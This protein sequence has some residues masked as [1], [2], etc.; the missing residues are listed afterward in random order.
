MSGSSYRLAFLPPPGP[1]VRTARPVANPSDQTDS[2]AP[3]IFH[4]ALA[5]RIPV[6]IHEQ[7]CNNELEID[8]MDEQSF[9]WV[10]YA[11][12]TDHGPEV[13]AATIRFIPP[14]P[15][16]QTHTDFGSPTVNGHPYY[17]GSLLWDHKEPF[18]HIG[19][20]ATVKAF[21]GRGYGRILVKEAF[22]T[23]KGYKD[24]SDNT[25]KGLI[26]IHSQ[27]YVEGWY[28]S[29]GFETDSGMGHWWEEGIEHT[30]MWKRV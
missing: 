2:S 7:K 30:A 21:R 13:P 24:R 20:L 9:H 17:E 18:A 29:C 8:E 16:G 23:A 1:S 15:Q 27:R 14:D 4:D 11:K 22:K 5:V 28:K 25:W 12:E 10:I 19:R 26:V 3:S 6:F